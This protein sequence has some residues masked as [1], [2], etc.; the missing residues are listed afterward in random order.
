MKIKV[1]KLHPDA[2]IPTFSTEGAAGADLYAIAD[3]TLHKRSSNIIATYSGI[4]FVKTGIVI[5]IPKGYEGQIR[6]RSGLAF[7]H[8]ISI[9]NT[10]GTID[11][12]YR[13]EIAIAMINLGYVDYDITAGDRIAQLVIK[14]VPVVTFEEVEELSETGRGDAGY[15]STG[16]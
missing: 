12:D 10:P 16:K 11:S 13:G 8:G 3:S 7:N 9:I 5:E 4:S 1:K 2:K 15:G 6:P 14:P